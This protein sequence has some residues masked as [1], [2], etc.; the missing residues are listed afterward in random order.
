VKIA[1][2]ARNEITIYYINMALKP[3]ERWLW[4]RIRLGG[5]Y[6]GSRVIESVEEIQLNEQ[7]V[8]DNEFVPN[9]KVRR[10]FVLAIVTFGVL[11]YIYILI[12]IK[13]K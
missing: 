6:V 9:L 10:D 7:L 5:R 8:D 3:R 11:I 4:F 13:K 1:V 2:K 12:K